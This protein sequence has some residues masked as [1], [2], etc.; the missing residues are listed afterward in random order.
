MA[1]QTESEAV[2]RE[3]VSSLGLDD[4]FS[5]FAQKGWTTYGAFAFSTSSPP[6]TADRNQ[7][8]DQIIVPVLGE[9]G[10]DH[11]L[12]PSLRRLHW[13]STLLAIGEMKQRVERTG[14]E[15]PRR[16]PDAER[17]VRRIRLEARLGSPS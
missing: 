2:F 8:T 6:G 14:D 7:I 10:Q 9:E 1:Q 13:E 4:F 11:Q 16:L 12:A 3:R 17:N 5:V 15:P